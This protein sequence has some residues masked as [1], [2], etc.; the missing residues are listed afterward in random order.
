MFE[1]GSERTAAIAALLSEFCWCADNDRGDEIGALF[2]EDAI[3]ETP[4]FRLDGRGEIEASFTARSGTKLSR[5]CWTNLRITALD[6]RRYRVDS[7]MMTTVGALPAPQPSGR[8]VIGSCIDEILFADDGRPL[9]KSRS[10]QIAF[11]GS[12]AGEIPA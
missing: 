3:V 11:E 5:H 1:V 10:L 7:N 6:E 12:L 8:L 4:H 9:F 2:T